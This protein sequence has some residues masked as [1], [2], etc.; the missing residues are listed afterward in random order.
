MKPHEFNLDPETAFD[1]AAMDSAGSW[2]ELHNQLV[3]HR[4]AVKLTQASVADVLN[5][6]QPAVSV[7]EGNNSLDT[8]LRTIIEYAAA[9]GLKINFSVEKVN[10]PERH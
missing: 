3:D 8:K 7:F 5:I 6:T 9:I 10:W 2:F 1:A 4:S